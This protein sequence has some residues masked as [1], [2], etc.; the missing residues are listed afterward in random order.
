MFSQ[1]L[2]CVLSTSTTRAASLACLLW[3]QIPL[4]TSFEITSEDSEERKWNAATSYSDRKHQVQYISPVSEENQFFRRLHTYCYIHVSCISSP[5]KFS[6]FGFKEREEKKRQR[7]KR[8]WQHVYVH[9]TKQLKRNL[10][11][12]KKPQ[13]PKLCTTVES[14]WNVMAH[15]DAREGKWRGN[16]RMEWVASTLHTTSE[17]GVSSITTADAHT[18]AASSRLN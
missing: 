10:L 14:S 12:A 15:G 16:C 8:S 9:L 7:L 6:F 2:Q 5:C 13:K 1:Q 18:S 3:G 4:L 17:H 11:E